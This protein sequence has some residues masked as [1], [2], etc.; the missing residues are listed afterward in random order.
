REGSSL[1]GAALAVAA[2]REQHDV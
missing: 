1:R 2:S